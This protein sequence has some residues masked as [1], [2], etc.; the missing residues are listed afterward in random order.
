VQQKLTE[1]CKSTIIKKIFKRHKNGKK[2][3]KKKKERKKEKI[4]HRPN[5]ICFRVFFCPE[6]INLGIWLN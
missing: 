6:T 2:K 3:E 4:Q 1:H 5:K